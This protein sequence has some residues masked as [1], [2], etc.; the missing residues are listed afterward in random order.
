MR[1]P[2]AWGMLVVVVLVGVHAP[3]TPTKA[4]QPSPAGTTV[5]KRRPA[6]PTIPDVPSPSDRTGGGQLSLNELYDDGLSHG[7]YP[8]VVLDEGA[9]GMDWYLGGNQG[10]WNSDYGAGT[11]GFWANFDYLLWWRQGQDLPP[12]VTTEPN[13]GVLPGA[14][15]LWGGERE[16][17]GARPGGRFRG[18][19][20]LDMKGVLAAEVSFFALGDARFEFATDSQLYPTL[21]RPFFNLLSD[22][23]PGGVVGPDALQI[24]VPGLST[25]QIRVAGNS[26][27]MG[28]DVLFR[29]L[30]NESADM[31]VD[32]LAGYQWARVDEALSIFSSTNFGTNRL[33]VFD[34]FATQNRFQ[35][36]VIG[37]ELVRSHGRW[38]LE[39]LGKLGFGNMK[40]TVTIDGYQTAV[41]SG[42]ASTSPGGLLA[43]STNI[44]T[45]HQDVFAVNPQVGITLN[46]QLTRCVNL[47][48]G[49]SFS[50]WNGIAR[51]GAQIDPQLAVN[52]HQPPEADEPARPAFQFLDSHFYLHGL[53]AGLE[54][55]Y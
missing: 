19:G 41:V 30:L 40:Q 51:P 47:A 5:L 4:A 10:E 18:G 2:V 52:P 13:G 54:F 42:I 34:S 44:G 49:Y 9:E 22:N 48:T 7:D 20:W 50:Y 35:G 26:E 29:G 6:G 32:L 28:G 33:D 45:Y 25:G 53:H 14:T 11:R 23:A 8:E 55:V 12:L 17:M 37:L 21:A 38:N 1:R 31:R 27:V 43:Q 15:I 36:G 24:A 46:C 3:P 16:G 39:L